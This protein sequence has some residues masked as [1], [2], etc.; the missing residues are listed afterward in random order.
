V[1]APAATGNFPHET[2]ASCHSLTNLSLPHATIP[3][4][5]DSKNNLL[6][7]SSPEPFT[8]SGSTC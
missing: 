5:L 7:L 2:G 4:D 8:G 6:N 3:A 1:V